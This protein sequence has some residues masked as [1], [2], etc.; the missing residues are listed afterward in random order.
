[1]TDICIIIPCYNE[2]ER[3]PK[4]EFLEY[5]ESSDNG[6]CFVNDGSS[7]KTPDLFNELTKGR[8]RIIFLDCKDNKGKAE[9][10]RYAAN[11]LL[12]NNDIQYIGYFDAD[13]ATPLWEIDNLM[14]DINSYQMVFG[15]RFKRLGATIERNPTRHYI[16]RI[17][18][19]IASLMLKLPIYDTQCGA[20]IMSKS[21]ASIAFKDSFLT[22]WLFDIE[23]FFRL[24]KN[25]SNNISLIKEVPL[26]QWIEKG[27]SKIKFIHMLMVPL[28]LLRIFFHY[29]R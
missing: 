9:A 18:A 29:R 11:Y 13:L 10:V 14:D 21:F 7:D 15:S 26:Q 16:G 4:E 2:Y 23:I 8:D 28:Q 25:D 22:S 1:M 19:T 24:K 17:F 20:K 6:F 12:E 27:G 5:Y 3:F